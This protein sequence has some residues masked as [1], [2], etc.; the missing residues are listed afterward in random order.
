MHPED[1]KAELRKKGIR[2]VALAREL[3]VTATTIHHVIYGSCRSEKVAQCIAAK[4]GKD[5]GDI[6]RGRYAPAV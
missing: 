5:V 4:I 2:Q 1:I 6:W 3:G